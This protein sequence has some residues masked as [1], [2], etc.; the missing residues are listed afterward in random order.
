MF[1]YFKIWLNDYDENG[2]CLL[3][4]IP[5]K[6]FYVFCLKFKSIT[7]LDFDQ[8]ANEKTVLIF[9]KRQKFFMVRQKIKVEKICWEEINKKRKSFKKISL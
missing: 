6:T 3:N 5:K 1:Y 9:K 4:K 2:K 8:I 7:Y